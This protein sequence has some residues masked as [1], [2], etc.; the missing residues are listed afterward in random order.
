MILRLA[1][2]PGSGPDPLRRACLAVA[3]WAWVASPAIATPRHWVLGPDD[4]R[5]V[6]PRLRAGDVLRLRPGVYEHGLPI[7]GVEGTEQSPIVIE[8]WDRSRPPVFRA[9]PGANTVSLV[10]CRHVRIAGLRLVGGGERVDAVKAEGHSRFADFVTLEGLRIEG[11]GPWQDVVGISTKCPARGWVVRGNLIEDAGTGM[12]FGNSDGSAPFVSARLEHNQVLRPVGYGIQIKHQLARSGDAEPAVTMV[13]HNLII[14]SGNS[15]RGREA[16]PNLLVGHGP[17]AGRGEKDRCLVY[18]NVLFGN[19]EEALLQAE[20]QL[21]IYNNL[22]SNPAG[23]ALRVMA[24][25]HRPRE[26]AVFHNTV[27]AAGVGIEIS[28][29]E[30]GYFRGARA[31]LV[32]AGEPER[33]EAVGGNRVFPAARAVEELMAPWTPPPGLQLAP[34]RGLVDSAQPLP[35]AWRAL[36]DASL[37]FEG[38]VRTQEFAGA[39]PAG[40]MR[41]G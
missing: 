38:A 36:P 2:P 19:P 34:R 22:L 13:R 17:L 20:G 1:F 28:G 41:C 18:G 5:R 23:D 33:G 27:A 24:H 25:K 40:G 35:E 21:A 30:P 39:C 31:N 37:D 6:L 3:A 10:D 11:H 16:R 15:S 9:R 29:G 32:F 12:Y 8:A 26:V 4:Y 14:K 7:H